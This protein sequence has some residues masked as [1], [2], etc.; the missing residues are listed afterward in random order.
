M[1]TLH[2]SIMILALCIM[3]LIPF[4]QVDAASEKRQDCKKG[5]V[6]FIPSDF[7]KYS[8]YQDQKLWWVKTFSYLNSLDDHTIEVNV[9]DESKKGDVLL[10]SDWWATNSSQSREHVSLLTGIS[11]EEIVGTNTCC[12]TF[13][14]LMPSPVEQITKPKFE[15]TINITYLNSKT[16]EG[17]YNWNGYE[18]SVVVIN[19][20]NIKQIVDKQTGILLF[21]ENHNVNPIYRVSTIRLT[22]TNIIQTS[23][24]FTNASNVGSNVAVNTTSN[25]LQYIPSTL[26]QSFLSPHKQF[27]SGITAMD[28]KCLQDL[29]L[30]IK[31]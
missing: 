30:I 12:Y 22:N 8:F 24:V 14:Y 15:K 2:L 9:T 17:N 5:M 28:V 21:L 23:N 7:I 29:Q 10:G 27:E 20:K 19:D 3:C 16:S 4:H 18:R 31:A 6:C 1:K 11:D 25:V 26:K 13:T